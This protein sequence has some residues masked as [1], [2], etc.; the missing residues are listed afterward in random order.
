VDFF[1]LQFFIETNCSDIAASAKTDLDHSAGFDRTV[2]ESKSSHFVT[3]SP[4]IN[5]KQGHYETQNIYRYI[6]FK[7]HEYQSSEVGCNDCKMAG[8][9]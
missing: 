8:I 9:F 3:K 5:K 7:L 1:P 6:R 2:S 4:A